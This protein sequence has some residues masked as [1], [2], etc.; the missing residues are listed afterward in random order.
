[1]RSDIVEKVVRRFKA[2]GSNLHGTL[3]NAD[4]GAVVAVEEAK[5]SKVVTGGCELIDED[6]MR[7]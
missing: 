7:L 4:Q 2:G 3:S 5:V 1:M 6:P